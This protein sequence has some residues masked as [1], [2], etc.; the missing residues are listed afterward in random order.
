MSS[1][2]T[3]KADEVLEFGTYRGDQFIPKSLLRSEGD[4]TLEVNADNGAYRVART[5]FCLV[6]FAFLLGKKKSV[7]IFCSHVS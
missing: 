3:T 6:F 4:G 2:G 7:L 5:I 1:D